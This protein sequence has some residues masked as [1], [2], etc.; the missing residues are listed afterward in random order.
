MGYTARLEIYATK[1]GQRMTIVSLRGRV[2]HV[3]NTTNSDRRDGVAVRVDNLASQIARA[4]I[5][6]RPCLN[7]WRECERKRDECGCEYV[8]SIFHMI[9]F[10]SFVRPSL[11]SRH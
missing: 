5:K 1:N 7:D 6:A 2:C 10:P 11:N 9:C 3:A 8:V 4:T